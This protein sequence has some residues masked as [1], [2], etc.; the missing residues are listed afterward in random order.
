MM[1]GVRAGEAEKRDRMKERVLKKEGDEFL[2]PP[3]K[4]IEG[5]A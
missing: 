3:I 2:F 5:V 1:K 4:K